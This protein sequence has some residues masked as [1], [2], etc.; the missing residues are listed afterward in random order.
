LTVLLKPVLS[1]AKA[2]R[3]NWGLCLPYLEMAGGSLQSIAV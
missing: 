1:Q 3:V 2:S